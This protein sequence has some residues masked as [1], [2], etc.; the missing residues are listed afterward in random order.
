MIRFNIPLHIE[1]E[2]HCISEAISSHKIY[3]DGTFTKKCRQ[4][5]EARTGISALLT[6]SCTHATELAAIMVDLQPGDEI[7]MPS[8]TFVSTANAFVLRDKNAAVSTVKICLPQKKVNVL[9]VCLCI[10]A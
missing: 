2:E 4:W 8:Y 5:I 6:T 9:Y 1:D 3:G 7:I 10:T